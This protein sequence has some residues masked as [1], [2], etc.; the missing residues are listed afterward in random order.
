MDTRWRH[1]GTQ[2][3]TYSRYYLRACNGQGMPVVMQTFCTNLTY[4]GIF[5]GTWHRS[6]KL[7]VMLE[8]GKNYRASRRR[9]EGQSLCVC[10]CLFRRLRDRCHRLFKS[11][12][13]ILITFRCDADSFIRNSLSQQ[14]ASSFNTFHNFVN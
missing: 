11:V 13:E 6:F 1:S 4:Y 7:P 9:P 2:R 10:V 12:L 5:L 3:V 8:S 14:A